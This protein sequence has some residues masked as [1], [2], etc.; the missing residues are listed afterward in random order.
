MRYDTRK[1]LT[2]N[3]TEVEKIVTVA[4]N[5]RLD[6]ETVP[7]AEKYL[8]QVTQ[9]R[10][11]AHVIFDLSQLDYISSF[12]LSLLLAMRKELRRSSAELVLAQVQPFV[13]QVLEI[14]GLDQELKPYET[15]SQAI[16]A[17][18]KKDRT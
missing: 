18:Q 17:L 14:A 13:A 16:E 11:G 7:E 15:L 5:G 12:G 2:I 8:V 1:K 9:Q 6:I 4:L 3:H 10:P